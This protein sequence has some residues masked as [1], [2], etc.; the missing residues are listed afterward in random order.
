[1]LSCSGISGDLAQRTSNFYHPYIP[2]VGLTFE[3]TVQ[4][5]DDGKTGCRRRW[6]YFDDND[7]F[8][9]ELDG[10]DFY[11]VKRSSTSGTPV[12]TRVAQAD[13]NRD[14]ADG[15][16]TV[17]LTLDHSKANMFWIDVQWYGAGRLRYGMYE[18]GGTRL[19]LHEFEHANTSSEYPFTRTAT[20]PVRVEQENTA[21]TAGTS[22]IRN[23]GT[24][25][26]HTHGVEIVGDKQTGYSDVK[27]TT[28][29]N[30]V[31]LFAVRPKILF[32]GYTNRCYF[33]G[34][35]ASFTNIVTAGGGPILYRIRACTEAALTN[36][37]FVSHGT[38]SIMEIDKSATALNPAF[39]LERA[40]YIVSGGETLF[41]QNQDVR[42]LRATEISLN[43]DGV[44]QP[45]LLITAECLSGTSAD[46][47][48]L[49]NWEEVKF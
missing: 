38:D 20:L 30:E 10:T 36:A 11:I 6:G 25:V 23:T 29:G 5:G 16:D 31:P 17:R 33:E 46:A 24:L 7:G 18:P 14:R 28:L 35:A 13:F 9:F 19:S 44:T 41:V 2:G 48:A 22:Q 15:S 27:T 21:A 3:Q 49:V 26:K 12:D 8:F 4:C 34:I 40:A 42:H 37:N 47:I 45:V 39:T 1:V 43:A 32:N